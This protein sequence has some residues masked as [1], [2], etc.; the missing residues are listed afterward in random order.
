LSQ[1]YSNLTGLF[2]D[3]GNTE[4]MT[5]DTYA[6]L[7]GQSVI[8]LVRDDLETLERFDMSMSDRQKLEAWKALLDDTGSVVASAQCNEELANNLALT[9]NAGGGDMLGGDI[10]S[11]VSGD[12]D[13]ADLFSN[14]AVLAAVCN[15]NPVIWL[16]YPGNYVFSGLGLS[17]ENHSA[18]HRI[19]NAGMGGACV[20]G[21]ND[22]LETIDQYYSRKFAHLIGTLDGIDEGNGTALDNSLVVWFQE[23]SD[24]NAHNLN[25]MPIVQ[26]GSAGGRFKMGEAINVWDGSADLHRGNS[27]DPCNGGG[28]I[29]TSDVMITGT[30]GDIANAPI[31]KYFCNLMNAIGVKAGAD[32][33]PAEGG[34][35]EVTHFG[36]Y[37]RTEDFVGGGTNPANISDPGEFTELLA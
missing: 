26:A 17:M 22:M 8:D 21:V 9:G 31:N 23:D 36:M 37:D 1:A 35:A 18:S 20:E 32:G 12:L 29:P 13:A 14:V 3:G 19:G 6:A 5:P 33:F 7:K 16:K 4:V 34:T 15:A 2:T 27:F 11:P 24:G 30:P 10:S 28:N 25:N